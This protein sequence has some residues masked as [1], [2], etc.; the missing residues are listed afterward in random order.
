MRSQTT[1][2]GSTRG[3]LALP[4]V[5]RY[6]SLA[7]FLADYDA[8]LSRGSVFLN[9]RRQLPVG[10]P[11]RVVVSLRQPAIRARLEGRVSRIQRYGNGVNEAPGMQLDITRADASEATRLRSLAEKYRPRR[12]VALPRDW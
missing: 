7:G 12:A 11:V 6:R 10:T 3:T 5:L 1:D 2:A 9:T 4:R 8:N